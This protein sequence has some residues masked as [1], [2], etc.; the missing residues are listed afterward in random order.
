MVVEYN[1][2]DLSRNHVIKG[3]SDFMKGTY[4]FN[5]ATIS[6]LVAIDTVVVEI[7]L[8]IYHLASRDHVFKGLCNFARRSFS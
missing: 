4:S 1:I 3:S 5:I 2:F 7:M 8:L 6:G